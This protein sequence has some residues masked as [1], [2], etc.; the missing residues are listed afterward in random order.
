MTSKYATTRSTKKDEHKHSFSV[1]KDRLAQRE[2]P[3]IFLPVVSAEPRLAHAQ[4]RPQADRQARS[5]RS[6]L[7]ASLLRGN[8]G[9]A[10]EPIFQTNTEGPRR[11]KYNHG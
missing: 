4:Y 7:G 3:E 2:I 10:R 1:E 9:L 5:E 11:A 6:A 8:Q